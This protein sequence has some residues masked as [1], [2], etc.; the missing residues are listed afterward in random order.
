MLGLAYERRVLRLLDKLGELLDSNSDL[1][2]RTRAALAGRTLGGTVPQNVNLRM[3]DAMLAR[4]ARLRRVVRLAGALSP[5]RS[6]VVRLTV[7]RGLEALEAE[8]AGELAA[9][10][11]EEM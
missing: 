6:A 11:D 7:E 1:A 5:S 4:L 3:S 10:E 8:Y 9:L 2:K